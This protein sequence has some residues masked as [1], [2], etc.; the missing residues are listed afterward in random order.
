MREM[1]DPQILRSLFTVA[2]LHS[3]VLLK[4]LPH[5][6]EIRTEMEGRRRQVVLSADRNLERVQVADSIA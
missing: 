1:G 2:P 4:P 6:S 3:L 5:G